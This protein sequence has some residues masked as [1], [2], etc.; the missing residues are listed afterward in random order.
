MFKTNSS[1]AYTLKFSRNLSDTTP[2]RD[3][4]GAI[5]VAINLLT[6]HAIAP[7]QAGFLLRREIL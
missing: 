1:A 6:E 4:Q 5:C 2:E 3:K 7:S